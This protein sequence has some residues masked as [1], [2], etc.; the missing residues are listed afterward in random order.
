MS[1]ESRRSICVIVHATDPLRVLLLRR[2]AARA[3]GWQFVSGR[4]EAG[5]SAAAPTPLLRGAIATGEL[6]ALAAAALREVHEETGLGEPLELRDLALETSF[7]GYDGHT[8]HARSFAARYA[9]ATPPPWTP[10]HEE[11][12]W[13]AADEAPALL[14]WDDD[15]RALARLQDLLARLAPDHGPHPLDPPV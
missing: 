2:P 10:E 5:D 6:P 4:V 14:T 8:Y 15:K 11:W 1:G 7:L 13:I 3:A 9:D 12:R